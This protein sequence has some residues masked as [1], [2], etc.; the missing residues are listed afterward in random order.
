MVEKEEEMKR[1]EQRIVF[2]A[3]DIAASK[4]DMNQEIK[5]SLTRGELVAL[6]NWDGIRKAAR[7]Q[8]RIEQEGKF[9]KEIKEVRSRFDMDWD[10]YEF[11]EDTDTLRVTVKLPP[12]DA[13]QLKSI[14][15]ACWEIGLG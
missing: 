3:D 13:D 10:G 6:G 14:L 12:M 4:G 9:L 2:A 8:D 11:S 1:L 7:N 5:F 15:Q